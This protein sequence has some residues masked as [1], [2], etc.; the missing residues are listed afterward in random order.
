MHTWHIE[1]QTQQEKAGSRKKKSKLLSSHISQI[2]M[3]R[4]VR[5]EVR[6][7]SAFSLITF[8]KYVSS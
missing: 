3:G 6:K 2:Q 5:P 1:I 4:W 8:F 7:L